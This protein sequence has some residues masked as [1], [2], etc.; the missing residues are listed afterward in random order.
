[1]DVQTHTHTHT[2]CRSLRID[3]SRYTQRNRPVFGKGPNTFILPR[4]LL[5]LL[6][7][8]DRKRSGHW[9]CNHKI[10]S[11][12]HQPNIRLLSPGYGFSIRSYHC[13]GWQIIGHANPV[14]L[15]N[16]HITLEQ[17][18]LKPSVEHYARQCSSFLFTHT[19]KNTQV[20]K[21]LYLCCPHQGSKCSYTLHWQV[22]RLINSAVINY[23]VVCQYVT[24]HSH[25]KT[26]KTH[27]CGG[28]Y[29]L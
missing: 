28:Y 27:C 5:N 23:A 29:V 20:D 21:F 19:H 11:V 24:L 17:C 7:L 10:S 2:L 18:W 14:M 15:T 8:A 1:M 9:K 16:G 25:K 13:R 22:T 6:Q 4:C 26:R 3:G 12:I